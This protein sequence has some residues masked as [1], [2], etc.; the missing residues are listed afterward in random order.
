MK[1]PEDDIQKAVA[2]HLRK[3]GAPGL[4]WWHTP[5][6]SK[7][8]GKRNKKGFPIQAARL[9]RFG[10]RAGVSDIVAV[11]KGQI[12]ALELK[13]PGGAAS[14]HQIQ[15]LQDMERAGAFICIA[16]GLDRAIRVLE[17][18]GL[19]VGEADVAELS[20]SWRRLDAIVPA[21]LEKLD[22]KRKCGQAA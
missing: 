16:E 9:K 1:H 7:L 15:F 8:G 22:P 4:V 12:F 5:N 2:D 14:E 10:V 17:A 20:D 19:L 13:A 18:W 11:H 3:R 21:L 6:G